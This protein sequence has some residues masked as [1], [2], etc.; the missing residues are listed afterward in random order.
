M[1]AR[2][3]IANRGEVAIRVARA[4]AELGIESVAV[5]GADDADSL[6]VA[7]ADRA[8]A[9]PGRG[10]GAYL[11]GDAII[12]AALATGAD[13]VHPGYGFL[14]E[15][16]AFAES[17]AAAGLTFVGP[18][19]EA[20][21]LFG[22]KAASRA[23]AERCG[24][25]VAAGTAGPTSL[26]QAKAFFA[27]L[28][29]GGAMMIKAVAGGG[30]RGMRLVREAQKLEEAWRRCGSEASSAFGADAL[31]VE[32]FLA[33]VRHVEVQVAGDR[34]GNLVHLLERECSVQRR[35]QKFLEIA[36]SP[37]LEPDLRQSLAAAALSI[38]E[39]VHYEGLG[40][41]E[42][43]VETDAA[44]QSTGR[45][46]FIEMN[47]R[48]QVEH[49][50]TE[51]VL[52]IDLV[53]TQ[54]KLA[55][56]TRLA[57]LGL[58]Q[59]AIGP[60]R[61][62]AVELRINME[63]LR[64]DGTAHPSGGTLSAFD[65]ST[66]AG[67]R[68]E[69][70]AYQGYTTHAGFDALLAKLIV[71]A[72]S[73]NFADAVGRAYR[74]LCEFRIEGV[75]TN[76]GLLQNILTHPDFS[77][78]RMDTGYVERHAAALAAG[79]PH[80]RL[81][82]QAGPAPPA[83]DAVAASAGPP[84]TVP[85]TAP[86][87]GRVVAIAVAVGEA[88]RAGQQVAVIEAMKMEHV[89]EASVSGIVSRVA[90][91]AGETVRAGAALVHLTP[92]EVEEIVAVIDGD[93][94]PDRIRPDLAELTGRQ[95]ALLDAARP[96]AVERRRKTGQRTTR[97]NI[98]DLCDAGSFVEYGGFALAAQR[99]RRSLEELSAISP[100]DGLVAGIGAVNGHLFGD[101]QA[102]CMVL[103]Y[104]YT[105]FAGTQGFMNHK[106]KDRML[107]LA[108]D[109]RLPVVVFAEG[110]GGRP[111][112]TDF[113]GVAG[114]DVPS[115][116]LFAQL[117]ALVPLVGI[118]SGRCFAGNAALLGCC[119]VIIATQRFLDRHGRPGDDRGRRARGLRPRGGR[120]GR[121]AGA[122]RRH[123]RPGGRRGRGG[124]GGQALSFLLPG[125]GRRLAMRRPAT[126]ARSRPGEPAA[127]LRHPAGHRDDR[128]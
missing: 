115:F 100:A 88:V 29:P 60:P 6:H 55:A 89:I 23:L 52:G 71:H 119:D 74:A 99:R 22:D 121:G 8:V 61:G 44:G 34:G 80:R 103:A 18:S 31:Y 98:A 58:R 37:W 76:L 25:P 3:L 5:H 69:T 43:L 14:S 9:L 77:A 91:A 81:H 126:L 49:T 63:T 109:Q 11:D 85:V 4:C 32:E 127:R 72:P 51:E 15:N 16:A 46:V 114:L 41:V 20:L 108:L 120:P 105:V 93:R 104:D 39:A 83:D 66:G 38:G 111:G 79:A 56:G 110:G 123:R 28:A 50:V 13:A 7:R 106:K 42:F 92:G 19:P 90:A 57:A 45:F 118:V 84:G 95:A 68:V 24:V 21:N 65:P 64:A 87:L 128:R 53:V 113:L 36:P 107:R 10:A 54:L 67:V 47:P 78:G 35:H 125:R 26:D 1:F 33:P 86:M 73:K 124:R 82:V 117:S 94:D 59:A 40:T 2:V 96:K 97:E 30:G 116:R 122:E 27:A 70:A 112:E 17:C 101:D 48:L 102:R 75:S 62:H 12:R